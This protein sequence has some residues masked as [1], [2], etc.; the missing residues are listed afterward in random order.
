MIRAAPQR[1]GGSAGFTLGAGG[2]RS[3]G[4]EQGDAPLSAGSRLRRGAGLLPRATDGEPGA[5]TLGQ[6]QRLRRG[7]SL[8]R[9]ALVVGLAMTFAC[10]QPAH[11]PTGAP[12]PD[13]KSVV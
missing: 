10:A 6:R 8:E 12:A 1:R 2:G 11:G 3:R 5:R 4:R 7:S 9:A 13:Q